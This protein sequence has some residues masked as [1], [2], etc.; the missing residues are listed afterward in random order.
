VQE[1]CAA[2]LE[3]LSHKKKREIFDAYGEEG[4]KGGGHGGG[5]G[6]SRHPGHPNSQQQLAYTFHR[7]PRAFAQF[8]GT[9]FC[10]CCCCC[11]RRA[12]GGFGYTMGKRRGSY[13][14]LI[15]IECYVVC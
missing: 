2:Q 11:C 6:P 10:Y 5:H 15:Y 3:I 1:I 9:F 8:F 12:E 7:D 13:M 4:L 14:D